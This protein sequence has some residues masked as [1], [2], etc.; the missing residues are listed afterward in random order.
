MTTSEAPA[1]RAEV[2]T[3]LTVFLDHVHRLER[4]STLPFLT[5]AW[6]SAWYD[7]LGQ[8]PGCIAL[9]LMVTDTRRGDIVALLPL[10]ARSERGLR[11]VEF[12][13][14]G[15]TDYVAPVLASDWQ[16]DLSATEAAQAL[17]TAVRTVLRG[18]DVLR[19]DKLLARALD[20][21]GGVPL[22][23]PLVQ[24]LP[25]R[26][27]RLFGSVF[28]PDADWEVWRR[29]LDKTV[30]KEIERC[31]RVFG[32][33]EAA[34]FE[35]VTEPTAALELLDVLERQQ[36]AR[37]QALGKD[38]RLDEPAYRAFYRQLL[39]DGLGAGRT[40]LSA[41]RSRGEVVAVLFGVSNALR[42]VAL[43]QG[44]SEDPAWRPISPGRL[45][46]EASARALHER[47]RTHCDFGIGDYRHK[48]VFKPE[49]IPLFEAWV[50]LSWRGR[51]AARVWAF[52]REAQARQERLAV[53][54]AVDVG[55]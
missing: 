23:N 10:V 36:R 27:S 30:R 4:P 33:D 24:A 34:R 19:L 6:L 32:R 22:E 45:L 29:S 14:A 38:Y 15:V 1:F 5:A 11:F 40:V 2:A 52:R 47:G 46:Y 53:P 13:D 17:W 25:V 48:D 37:M 31:W 41:L 8:A 39:G 51:M 26:P 7:T 12:A 55:A 49:R 16:G 3:D 35:M 18:H 9:P 21:E 20:A 54:Q 50:G 43:R 44:M 42:F 28:T